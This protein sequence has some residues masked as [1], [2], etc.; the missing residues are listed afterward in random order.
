MEMIQLVRDAAIETRYSISALLNASANFTR[1]QK[2]KGEMKDVLNNEKKDDLTNKLSH[3]KHL[4]RH[5]PSR[6]R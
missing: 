6:R 1:G 2:R 4:K 5:I 3:C